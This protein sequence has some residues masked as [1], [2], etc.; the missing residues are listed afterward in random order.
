MLTYTAIAKN[1]RNSALL[2]LLFL[3]IISGLGYVFALSYNTPA[4]LFAAV[5]FS[6]FSA[7]V[8][9]YFSSSI[10]LAMSG[11]KEIKRSDSPDLYDLVENLTIAAGL[12]L[13]KIYI[14]ADSA[15]N[16]FATGRDPKHA[17]IAVT[18]G[19]VQRLNKTEL[20]GVLAHELS[21][22]GNYDIRFMGI[23]VVLVGTLTLIADWMLRAAF[24]TNRDSREERGGNPIFFIVGIVLAILSPIIAALLQLAVSRQRE[25]LADSSG[26]HLTRYPEG[27]A[28]ALEKIAADKEPLEV[29]NKATAHLYIA[30]PFHKDVGSDA[31][32]R[33]SDPATS[34]HRGWFANLFNTHPPV[35]DRIARLRSM[36][37]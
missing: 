29:A 8:S 34:G 32:G 6:L 20:E 33:D 22:I 16:A 27:L 17:V 26:A 37:L 13:P 2:I 19:A 30:N 1:K 28:N 14:I 15:I 7:W 23:V 9:Y 31:H 24:F 4:I 25:Y 5:L 10:A 11:A 21:H 3:V 18:T 35:R 12:P 36:N